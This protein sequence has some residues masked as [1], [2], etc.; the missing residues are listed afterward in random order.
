M[1]KKDKDA[2]PALFEHCQKVYECMVD[3]AEARLVDSTPAIVYEGFLTALFKNE[4][5]MSVPY[6][7]S[8]TRALT[9]MGCIVQLRRGGS[10]TPSQWQLVRNPDLDTFMSLEPVKVVPKYV[11]QEEFAAQGQRL[12]DLNNRLITLERLFR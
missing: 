10:S 11:T 7:T 12:N 1:G 5:H 9:S 3:H 6:Y 4:L 8:V 2:P